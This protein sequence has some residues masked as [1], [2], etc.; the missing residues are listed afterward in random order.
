MKIRISPLTILPLLSIAF[1]SC[2]DDGKSATAENK[3]DSVVI[4]EEAVTYMDDTTNLNGFVTYNSSQEGK[5]PVV[6]VVHEWWG[7]TEFVRERAKQLAELGY[8]AMVVDMYGSGKKGAN[9]QEALALATPFYQ[10]PGLLKS[11]L[12][13]ALVKAGTYSQ[14]DTSKMA[15]IGYC[16]GGSMVLNDA[17]LGAPLDGVVSFHGGLEGVPPNKDILKAEIL[18]LHGDADTFVPPA[19]VAAFRKSLDSV[20][21]NYIFKSYP[22]ALH[23]FTN[24]KADEYAKQFNIPVAY[25]AEADKQSWSEMKDF[26]AR[27]LK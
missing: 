21:A 11:R 2:A 8:L 7:I 12:D 23:A 19:Q 20:D 3:K 22:G 16:F 6:F 13:A 17:K 27:I 18:V 9:P 10:N 4:T 1:Y 5:R 25:N 15:A 24:P 14:A 26:L